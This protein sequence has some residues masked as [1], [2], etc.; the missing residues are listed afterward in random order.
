MTRYA[1][2]A[3]DRRIQIQEA[4]EEPDA[5]GD[6]IQVWEDEFRLW[7][8]RRPNK[9]GKE[10]N[11]AGGTLRQ[12]DLTFRVRDNDLSRRI[13]PETHRV[14]YKGKIYEIISVLPG[15]DRE[16]VIDVYVAAR[17]DQRG[18]RGDDAVTNGP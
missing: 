2:G 13:A 10:V 14:V 11:A 12:F 6:P 8:Q 18:P 3:F 1:A 9:P 17:P 7:S 16:D 4:R 5:S 15:Q